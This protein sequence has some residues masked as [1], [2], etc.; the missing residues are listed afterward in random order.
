MQT[1]QV[2]ARVKLDDILYLECYASVTDNVVELE[3]VLLTD[4]AW[5]HV[6]VRGY[7]RAA[8]RERYGARIEAAALA[9]ATQTPLTGYDAIRHAEAHGLT[10]SKYADPLEGARDGLCVQEARWIALDDPSLIYLPA[11]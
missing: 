6:W 10:L 1:Q 3:D 9:A 2:T 8:M 5:I 11:L 7:D 4:G